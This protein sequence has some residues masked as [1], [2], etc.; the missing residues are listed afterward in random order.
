MKNKQIQFSFLK[1]QADEAVTFTNTSGLS[2]S[3]RENEMFSN[4]ECHSI[5]FHKSLVRTVHMAS[6]NHKG[7]GSEILLGSQKQERQKYDDST[8]C[9]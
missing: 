1:K 9:H 5:F 6:P 2:P 7:S 4:V 8:D 3:W